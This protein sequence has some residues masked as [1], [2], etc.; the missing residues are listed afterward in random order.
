MLC[1]NDVFSSHFRHCL[2]C[3]PF[4]AAENNIQFGHVQQSVPL[5][6]NEGIANSAELYEE[7][8]ANH[9]AGMMRVMVRALYDYDA[10]EDDELSLT[11]GE[12]ANCRFCSVRKC[13]YLNTLSGVAQ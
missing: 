8:A 11:A 10:V 9:G 7:I 12:L 5:Y 3:S 2:L 1:Y 4:E 6:A 13:S